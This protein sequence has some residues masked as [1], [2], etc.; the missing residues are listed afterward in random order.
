MRRPKLP[1]IRRAKSTPSEPAQPS[2]ERPRRLA[3]LARKLR[4]RRRVREAHPQRERRP[5]RARTPL[6][7]IAAL[8]V[9][10]SLRT[11]T[12]LALLAIIA[13][14]LAVVIVDKLGAAGSV[15]I[16]GAGAGGPALVAGF[17]LVATKN[18]TRIAASDP[19]AESAAVAL[20]VY[21]GG[22][23][24]PKSVALADAG[25]WRAAL[26]ASEL[27][28]P[29][30]RAP[31]ILTDGH[32]MSSAGSAAYARLQPSTVIR[33]GGTASPSAAHKVNITGVNPAALA[34]N[35]A[36]YVTSVRGTADNRAM[37]VNSDDPK[38]AM[39]AAGW[40]AKSG[41]PILFVNRDSVPPETRDAIGR[42][43]QPRIYVIGPG[44]EVGL[45]AVRELRKL[46][47]VK[48]IRGAD[49][50]T[51]AANFAQY[52]DGDFGWGPILA[53]RG[54]VF[55]STKQPLAAPAAA[56]LSASGTYGALLLVDGSGPKLPPQD[57]AYLLNIQPGYASDP[58]HG[59]YNHAWLVGD[60]SL[61]SLAAQTNIDKLLEILPV[62]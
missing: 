24:R 50:V 4:P 51:L 42:L 34:A 45:P 23:Q 14:L 20:A 11:R 15:S 38:F 7:Q 6:R 25:D 54:V 19:L 43:Q 37:V 62:K 9:P 10:A 44:T 12:S 21:P 60:G 18:T 13:V 41:D 58:A 29:S 55:A 36:A 53:G 28:A 32:G 17:P 27:M 57:V 47:H 2:A 49:P 39:A 33:V 40:A 22:G 3:R 61:I 1:R 56:A 35:V 52:Q 31:L 46:G 26:V 30:V 8:P 5:L 48:R 59:V 16:S